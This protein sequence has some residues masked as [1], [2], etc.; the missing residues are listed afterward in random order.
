MYP[1]VNVKITFLRTDVVA[2]LALQKSVLV[3][4]LL[5]QQMAPFQ[6]RLVTA[7]SAVI[8]GPSEKFA[9]VTLRIK[10]IP[11][12]L[13]RLIV[14][15]L[16]RVGRTGRIPFLQNRL[17]LVDYQCRLRT[18]GPRIDVLGIALDFPLGFVTRVH[19]LLFNVTRK[20]SLRFRNWFGLS[21]RFRLLLFNFDI[22]L[23]NL[24]L[25]LNRRSLGRSRLVGRRQAENRKIVPHK[26]SATPRRE[27]VDCFSPLLSRRDWKRSNV[28]AD[29]INVQH[30]HEIDALQRD[31]HPPHVLPYVLLRLQASLLELVREIDG[32]SALA[33]DGRVRRNAKIQLRD[34]VFQLGR[35]GSRF[36]IQW[37]GVEV[38]DLGSVVYFAQACSAHVEDFRR[39]IRVH[40]FRF[41]ASKSFLLSAFF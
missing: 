23:R 28:G 4:Q 33:A 31:P 30:L 34:A 38:R 22:A 17:H 1:H 37:N 26:Y 3:V 13:G 35:Y 36:G 7:N 11:F 41:K 8:Q 6:I 14:A 2:L 32:L 29:L 20:H 24:L 39:E 16:R 18:V 25:N 10:R 21:N 12:Y 40:Y 5:M 27:L 9:N 19:L 15:H